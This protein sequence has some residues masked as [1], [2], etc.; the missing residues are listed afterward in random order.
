MPYHQDNLVGT[1]SRREGLQVR[2]QSVLSTPFH[3]K[4]YIKHLQVQ[5]YYPYD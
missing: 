3:V 1:A 2:R 4:S 5:Y